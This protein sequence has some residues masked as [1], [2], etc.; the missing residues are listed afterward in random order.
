MNRIYRVI[1]NSSIGVW[2]AVSEIGKSAGKKKNHGRRHRAR[3]SLIA[4][5]VFIVSAQAYADALP[6]NGT[7]SLGSGSISQPNGKTLNITQNTNKMAIDWQSFNVGKDSVVNFIQPSSSSVALN[8]VTGSDVSSI[9]GAINANGQVFLINP[10]GILFGTTAQVNVGGLIASTRNL[11]NENFG[12]DNYL[13]EGGNSNAVVNQGRLVAAEGGYVVMIAAKIENMGDIVANQG[14]VRLAAGD[15]VLVNMGGTV[16]V[17]VQKGAIDALI[18][19]GGA[20]KADGG[21]ILFTAKA[22]SDLTASVVNNTGIVEATSL[23]SRGGEIVFM[24]DDITNSG[25]LVADGA[26][27]GGEILIGGDWQG[28]NADLYPHATKVTLTETSQISANATT[29]GDG[30]KVVVWSDVND[31]ESVTKV[32]GNISAKGLGEN[33]NGGKIETSGHVLNVAKGTTVKASEWL[34]DPTNIT[35]SAG[36]DGSLTSGETQSD[37]GAE[38]IE[39]AL[40]AG[41]NVTVQTDSEVAGEGDITLAANISKSSGADATLTLTAANNIVINENVSIT[42]TTGALNTVLRADNDDNSSGSVSMGAGSSIDTNGGDVWIGGATDTSPAASVTTQAIT[43]AAGNVKI[44][45]TGDISLGSITSTGTVELSSTGAVTQTGAITGGQ[46]LNLQGSGTYTLTNAGNEIASLAANTGTL[47]VT[48]NHDFSLGA[49]VTTGD[50]ELSSTG[51]VTQTDGT[52]ITGGQALNLLGTEGTYILTNANNEIG[53]LTANTG[54]VELVSG[55]A[56]T[57][58]AIT[59]TGSL[60]LTS[61]AL[62]INGDIDAGAGDIT[63]NT[64]ALTVT[65]STV[66]STGALQI[67]AKTAS[68]TI[69][70]GGGTGT[71]QVTA[72]NFSTDF[73]DGFSEITIGGENQSGNIDVD[74]TVL[75]DALTLQTKG[76]ITQNGAITGDQNL[77]L[78]GGGTHTLNNA[79]NAIGQLTATSGALTFHGTEF[80]LGNIA[81]TGAIQLSSTGTVTQASDT[82]ITGDQALSLFGVNGAYTLNNT[83][84]EIAS[85]AANTGSLSVTNNHNFSLGSIITTGDVELSSTGEVTQTGAIIGDQALNLLGTGTYTL[86]NTGNEIASLAANTG[87]LSVTNNHDFT[88]GSIVTTGDVTLSSDGTVTQTGAII[89]GQALNLQGAGTYTLTNTGNEI[90]SLAANTGSLSVT[91]NHDFTLGSIVTTGAVELSSTGTVTQATDTAIT[92]DQALNLLGTGTYTLTNANNAIGTLTADTGSVELV[93]SSAQITGAITTK[94]ALNLTSDDLTINENIATGAGNITFNTDSLTIASDKTVTGSGTLQVATKSVATTIGVNGGSGAL[95]IS[96]ADFADGFSAITIGSA[97]HTGGIEI[98]ANTTL[99]DATTLQTGGILSVNNDLDALANNLTLKVGQLTIADD[100]TISGTGLLT[101]ASETDSEAIDIGGTSQQ[102]NAADFGSKIANGFSDIVIGG[103]DQTGGINIVE[104]STLAAAVTMQTSGALSVDHNLAAGANNLTLKV[105]ELSVADGKAISGS[106]TLNIGSDTASD[107]ISIVDTIDNTAVDTLQLLSADFVSKIADSFSG[108]VIGDSSQSGNITIGATAFNDALTLQTTGT[109]TQT[110]A[111]TGGQDLNLLGSGGTHTLTNADNEIGNLTANTGSVALVNSL[112][113]TTGAITTSGA[114]NLTS[115]ALTINENIATGAGN[116]TF[117]TDALT[118]ADGKTVAGSGT[119]Q[120][121]TKTANKLIDVGG[122]TADALQ[123]TTTNISTDFAD[124]F[125]NITIGGV[126]HTG[127]IEI[128]ADTTFKDAA[129]LQTSGAL[130]VSNNLAAGANNLTLKVGE[131]SVA[132]GK[133][134]SGTGTLNITSDTASDAIS[135]VDT[136]DDNAVDTLQLLSA[137]FV[138]KIADGFSSIVIGDSSQ[139]GNITIGATAFNDALTL[140]STGTVTQ[141]GAITGGQ[142]LNLLGTGGTHTLTDEGNS[143]GTLTA[144]TGSVDF[145]HSA[146]LAMGNMTATTGLTVTSAGDITVGSGKTLTAPIINLYSSKI[147]N[148]GTLDASSTTTNGG[149]ITLAKDASTAADFISLE[150]VLN[151]STTNGTGGTIITNGQSVFLNTSANVTTAGNT[152]NG[153]WKTPVSTFDTVVAATGGDITGQTISDALKTANYTL[154]ASS[155]K[156][157]LSETLAGQNNLI[158]VNTN[159]D[160]TSADFGSITINDVIT[161]VSAGTSGTSPSPVYDIS[162]DTTLTISSKNDITINSAISSEKQRLNLILTANNDATDGGDVIFGSNG[163]VTTNNGNF[164]VGSV[165]LGQATNGVGYAYND[166]DYHDIVTASA[167]NFTMNTGSQINVGSGSLVLKVT[168]DINLPTGDAAGKSF[169][170]NSTAGSSGYNNETE[171]NANRS[172]TPNYEQVATVPT[173]L[174]LEAGGSI[175]GAST[176]ST[177]ISTNSSSAMVNVTSA[178]NIGSEDSPVLFSS[179]NGTINITN[180]G[181]NSYIKFANGYDDS[182]FSNLNLTTDVNTKNTTQRIEFNSDGSHRLLATTDANGLFSIATGGFVDETSSKNITI[183]APNITLANGAIVATGGSTSVNS[184]DSSVLDG[185]GLNLTLTALSGSTYGEIKADN[186]ADY[187]SS[188]SAPDDFSNKEIYIQNGTLNLNASN[189]GVKNSGDDWSNALEVTA[190]TLN[191]NNSGGSTWLRNS[192]F[193]SITFSAVDSNANV[194]GH[195]HILS[196][197]GDFFNIE[198]TADAKTIVHTIDDMNKLSGIKTD[199]KNVSLKTGLS[200]SQSRDI[201]MADNAIDIGAATLSLT[202]YYGKSIS[203][204]ST[205]HVQGSGVITATTEANPDIATVTV[206]NLNLTTAYNTTNTASIGGSDYTLKVARGGETG[207]AN[208]G[209]NVLTINN[210]SGDIAINELSAEHFKTIKVNYSSTDS[211]ARAHTVAIDLYDNNSVTENLNY[212]DTGN[213]LIT[214]DA[215]SIDLSGFNRNFDLYAY[216]KDI[217]VNNFYGGSGY[218][219]VT[220]YNN[221]IT[222]NG[223]VNTNGGNISLE[224]N[225]FKLASSSRIDSNSDNASN[226]T[227]LGNSGSISL[228]NSKGSRGVDVSANTGVLATLTLDSSS[229]NTSGGSITTDMNATKSAG[230][231]LTGLSFIGSGV[232]TDQDGSISLTGASFA[233]NGDFTATGNVAL[234]GG[235]STSS[236]TNIP[237]VLIDTNQSITNSGD[238]TFSGYSL[239]GNANRNYVFN[240]SSTGGNGGNVNLYPASTTGT[241]SAGSMTVNASGSTSSGTITLPAVTTTKNS[242]SSYTTT[243]AQSYTGS[244]ITLNGGLQSNQANIDVLGSE[245]VLANDVSIDTYTGFVS[246]QIST[247]SGVT[248]GSVT[249]G[250]TGAKL[251]NNDPTYSFA[252]DTSGNKGAETYAA[253]NGSIALIDSS[254]EKTTFN[255]FSMIGGGNLN[256]AFDTTKY[257]ATGQVT[258]GQMDGGSFTWSDLSAGNLLLKGPGNYTVTGVIGTGAGT[259]FAAGTLAATGVA[260]LNVTTENALVVGSLSSVNGVS[261]TGTVSIA[262]KADDLTVNNNITTTSAANGAITLNAGSTTDAGTATGGNVLLNANLTTGSGGQVIVYTGSIEDSGSYNFGDGHYRYNSDETSKNYTTTLGAGKYAIYREQP[263]LTI[264]F[265]FEKV[266]DGLE[267]APS[268]TSASFTGIVNGDKSQFTDQLVW[269]NAVEDQKI[270]NA[271]EYNIARTGTYTGASELGYKVVNSENLKYTIARKDL[272]VSLANQTKVYDGNTSAILEAKDFSITGFVT[273]D[274]KT[275]GASV[276]QVEGTYNDKNVLDAKTVTAVLSNKLSADEGTLL[277]NYT[278]QNNV[279]GNASI[280]KRALTASIIDTPTK[281]YDGNTDA[282]LTNANFSIANLVD[283]ESFTVSKASGTYNDKDVLDASSVTTSLAE[284]D[285]TEGSD[286]LASN[287]TMPVTATG[288]GSITARTLTASIIDTPTKVYDGNT[289]ATLTNGNFSIANLVDGESF[290]VTKATGAYNDKDVVDASTVTTSLAEGDFTQE[291]ETLA[292]NYIM[293]VTATGAGSITARTLTASIIDTPTKVYDGNTNATLTNDNYSLA[294]LVAG[295]SFTVNK[296]TGAYNDKDVAD[297]N[298]VTTS[299]V[300]DDF[301]AGDDTLKSNYN[302]PI[303]AT[304]D[305]VITVRSLVAIAKTQDKI[306]DA[307]TDAKTTLTIATE[308]VNLRNLNDINNPLVV[309]GVVGNEKVFLTFTDASFS[310]E[311]VGINKT[312]TVNG[313]GVAGVDSANYIVMVKDAL[314]ALTAPASTMTTIA[315]I[316]PNNPPVVF[317]P[318]PPPAPV[319]IPRPNLGNAPVVAVGGM[320]VVSIASTG[321]TTS[322]SSGAQGEASI[323][324]I[325]LSQVNNGASF[326]NQVFIV[327][328]G[329]NTVNPDQAVNTEETVK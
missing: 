15:S 50:I 270:L 56:Q 166:Q 236:A 143:I 167:E 11:T 279:T 326:D 69:G 94:G 235:E 255:N 31:A 2:Q 204:Y 122:A 1:W 240:T 201:I 194:A 324:T 27:G 193:N 281:V 72:T 219:N 290:T 108:I 258:I 320:Q 154:T 100:K 248:A 313:L 107:A 22:A 87:T 39:T 113:Q 152:A 74:A 117:N 93:N 293:P 62:T 200:I 110:G 312:V 239:S 64:D 20:I 282:T 271:G 76:N 33:A 322:V 325:L 237:S 25:T 19:N 102:L 310:D 4:G 259:D 118:I 238:I 214:L 232:T 162:T 297:A 210:E 120:I 207:E 133:A 43:A 175:I 95:Q 308:D 262:T 286:T 223:D 209:S 141:T 75:K 36:S 145:V 292:S 38:T 329:I 37:I 80:T 155:A 317:I 163:S 84:N 150:G 71:L 304:G 254:T 73:V 35:I 173:S 57:T 170:I 316:N 260:N 189:F 246:G 79:D 280:T 83:G 266:Y 323:D 126:G 184:S 105:G 319:V 285:F 190:N 289:D 21:H 114:L 267:L 221:S 139:S 10:N 97:D 215:S 188:T 30:G 229:S 224:S 63:F 121:T 89:G 234:S 217:Q 174:T 98:G 112:D 171:T 53:T 273:V 268:S 8:R 169:S 124:G 29:Q 208:V 227:S 249:I 321:S 182:N 51:T 61:D 186:A 231:Y 3:L 206:G 226:S 125:A 88:L 256:S 216:N 288:E 77:T 161:K 46:A 197:N 277:S 187:Y 24:G 228:N 16:S 28:A 203:A 41:T 68:A 131:L 49:I 303:T 191:V 242:G 218:F 90:A 315:D 250:S 116:I 225:T 106:G 67:A 127:G 9:Q 147:T 119:L 6:T 220:S 60:S 269:K 192:D 168:D 156:V 134:I 111:I 78:I 66:K 142:D 26:T 52:A 92:G 309:N 14:S 198:T 136:I 149:N 181:G 165:T 172:G 272:T 176:D 212:S 44:L 96:T 177:K 160:I 265:S 180:T 257:S 298:N 296:T 202:S 199:N 159:A 157:T 103:A 34:L 13:F 294:N 59:T 213:G 65:S 178:E 158:D 18:Q 42:S 85:L 301:E 318:A 291:N 132:D 151:A 241:F 274:G 253:N 243:S 305:A 185:T 153:T 101:V 70:I 314:G 307:K 86:N 123:L 81:T 148:Q 233:L 299:L 261:A 144:N 40:N 195:H 140:Q 23:T 138:S 263:T 164:Y 104:D 276:T 17:E 287:Y 115:D 128:G 196:T 284:G 135:I 32:A 311:Q 306:F 230:S 278:I 130:S 252:I 91:N 99:N 264:G 55:S 327:D 82:A 54:S 300:A 244:T 275:E 47:S 7:V 247:T 45:S 251:T 205:D 137:D 183:K 245:V 302:L 179:S 48:N 5:S 328:G 211:T 295:E 283:G 58:G 12:A 129:I 109:V 222:L 146:A